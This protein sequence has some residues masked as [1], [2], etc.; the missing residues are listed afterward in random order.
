M[1][2]EV[3]RVMWPSVILFSLVILL[4]SV[5]TAMDNF[6]W[7]R[8]VLDETTGETI[9]RCES[10]HAALYIAPIYILHF[11]PTVLAG[12]MAFKTSGMDDLYS[13]AKWVLVFILVQIQVR[14]KRVAWCCC[15]C[16][17]CLTYS[18]PAGN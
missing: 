6:V 13:E 18:P 11:V 12:I 2:I 7:V 8:K 1:Q 10:E 16:C 3:W 15:S 4:L 9:G 17:Q 14:S 5:W